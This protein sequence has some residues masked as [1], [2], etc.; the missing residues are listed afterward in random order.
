MRYDP[1]ISK[2]PQ[3]VNYPIQGG[4]A[5][6][7]MRALRRVYDVLAAQP[8]LD[9]QVVG[10]IHDELMLEAPADERAEIAA[11][12]LQHEMR[13]ALL[14]VFPESAAMGADRLA[15]AEVLDELGGEVLTAI[16][17]VLVG[18]PEP[19]REPARGRFRT[20]RQWPANDHS[21][22]GRRHAPV[23]AMAAPGRRRRP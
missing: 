11:G 20:R 2:P 10:A 7:Q 22:Q 9:T 4:A 3:A 13:A 23:S 21:L 12:I 5:S 16:K 15:E 6:V 8:W 17:I 14:E 19:Y 18:V 1:A